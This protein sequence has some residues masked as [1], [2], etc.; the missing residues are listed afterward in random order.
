M[1]SLPQRLLILPLFAPLPAAQTQVQAPLPQVDDGFIVCFDEGATSEQIEAY[2]AARGLKYNNESRWPGAQGDPVTITWSFIPDGVSIPGNLGEPTAPNN[3]FATMDAAFGG[4]RAQWVGLMQ[5]S[6]DRWEELS[7][8]NFERITFGGND[9]DDGAA[10]G[11]NGNAN[12]GDIRISMHFIDGTPSVSVLA[13]A[14][15]P[16]FSNPGDIIMD[17]AEDWGDP[18][19]SHIFLRNIMMHELGHSLGQ[20]H[21][22][23]NGIRFLMEPL[24]VNNIDGPR[25]DEIRAAHRNYGDVNEPD[26]N[27]LQATDLGVIS[28]APSTVGIPL[29]DPIFGGNPGASSLVSIDANGEQDWYSFTLETASTFSASVTPRGLIYDDSDQQFDGS[30][31][32]TSSNIDSLSQQNLALQLYDTNG[33]SVLRQA[34]SSGLGKSESLSHPLL[35]P[36][37]YYLRVYETNFSNQSQLYLLDLEARRRFFSKAPIPTSVIDLII[38]L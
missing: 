11:N 17:S 32:G 1:T 22:C 14:R 25:H 15:L 19:R 33:T 31:P 38:S 4:N 5:D 9:W 2:H 12:R 10:W 20:R 30:C 18:F 36:G 8:I 37:T 23:S 13:Y 16:N 35:Q 6:F 28:G 26:N 34:S 7:G 27:F 3:L 24:F 21:V 29:P